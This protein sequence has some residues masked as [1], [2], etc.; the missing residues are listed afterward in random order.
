MGNSA[1]N[2]SMSSQSSTNGMLAPPI[3][4]TSTRR[5]S[6]LYQAAALYHGS[7]SHPA[8]STTSDSS[9]RKTKS[10]R[11]GSIFSSKKV[12]KT[13]KRRDVERR[14]SKQAMTTFGMTEDDI[15]I[16][17]VQQGKQQSVDNFSEQ[18]LEAIIKHYEC[19]EIAMPVIKLDSGGGMTKQ[20]DGDAGDNNGGDGKDDRDGDREEVHEM[21]HGIQGAIFEEN[22]D[23]GDS[24]DGFDTSKLVNRDEQS[25]VLADLEATIFN[26]ENDPNSIYQFPNQENYH[27][28]DQEAA[29]ED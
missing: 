2:S 3:P 23:Q 6:T 24:G 1:G 5:D 29:T 19:L 17:K 7:Y 16:W 26:L 15:R 8:A 12:P 18:E 27:D 9:S 13:E 4:V 11:S 25:D 22:E 21:D 10:T 20:D 14:L 28:A